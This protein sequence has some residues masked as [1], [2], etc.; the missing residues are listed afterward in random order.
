MRGFG[1]NQQI[2]T[3]N[4]IMKL[5]GK[6]E[7]TKAYLMENGRVHLKST[8]RVKECMA[9]GWW[10]EHRMFPKIERL[11]C[12]LGT[13]SHSTYE[14]EYFERPRSLKSSLT[15]RQ[16]RLYQAL[17]KLSVY[18]QNNADA[19]MLW[20]EAFDTLPGEFKA[21]KE[22]LKEAVDNLTNYSTG[23]H[24]EISPRNVAVKGGKLI[25]LDCFFIRD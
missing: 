1:V 7:F 2:N 17:R 25:L 4:N 15:A 5:L 19:Y 10:P 12:D 23:V 24:F 18:V 11:D 8:D 16:W 13:D 14:M 3:Y 9:L 21:E 6:G 20:H 22:A